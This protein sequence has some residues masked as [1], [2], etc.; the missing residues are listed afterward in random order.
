VIDQLGSITRAFA[1]V[2]RITGD[3]RWEQV[4]QERSEDLLVYLALSAF[5]G[6]PPFNSLDGAL[7]LDVR[8]FF[9][10]YRAACV[11]AD[12][13]LFSAGNSAGVDAACR[14]ADVGK[15]TPEALYIHAS[16]LHT[17]SPVLRVLEGCARTLVGTVEGGNIIKLGRLKPTVTY[18]AYPRFDSDPHPALT[19]SVT[20]GLRSLRVDFRSYQDSPNPPI[21]HRKELFV[22]ASYPHRDMF[23]R[24][25]AQEVRRGLYEHPERI[26]TRYGWNM[27]LDTAHVCHRGHRL[28]RRP[29]T[30]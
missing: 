15:L 13:L 25:T 5:G 14:A 20:A 3:E 9:G 17:L 21:L 11:E 1:L 12:R 29:T 10:S 23:A 8:T 6:R 27:V 28:Q 24:L 2:R 7:R 19:T 16:G 26:G 22:P 4:R 18:L 30:V